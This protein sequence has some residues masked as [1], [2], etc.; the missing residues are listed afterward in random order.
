[1]LTVAESEI[2]EDITS[3]TYNVRYILL[4]LLSLH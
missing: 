1:M 2:S 4:H 3:F